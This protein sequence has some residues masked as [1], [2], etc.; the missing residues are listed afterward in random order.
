MFLPNQKNFFFFF[1]QQED[2]IL[3]INFASNNV[4]LLCG[5]EGTLHAEAVSTVG[6]TYGIST[7][8]AT[9]ALQAFSDKTLYPHFSR[10]IG[11]IN[12]Q[13]LALID[14]L[15]YYRNIQGAQGWTDFAV[16][17]SIEFNIGTPE[18]F[19]TL[20]EEND[21]VAVAYQQILEEQEDLS[22]EL[23]AIKSS[24]AR[25]I[26]VFILPQYFGKI[27]L[28]ANELGLVG[29]HYV[30]AST[31][32]LLGDPQIFNGLGEEVTQLSR[33][34]VGTFDYIPLPSDNY[35]PYNN[36]V[37]QWLSLDPVEYPGAGPG[38]APVPFLLFLYDSIMLAGRAMDK[39]D[40]EGLLIDAKEGRISPEV[41]DYA[42]RNVPFNGTSGP[43]VLDEKGDRIQSFA[44][45]YYDPDTL[46]W[47]FSSKWTPE[48]GIEVVNEIIWYSNT[49]EI[50]DLDIRPPFDYWSCH[51]KEKKHDKTGKTVKIQT[52]DGS[53]IDDIDYDYYCDKFIDCKNFS[54]E[55]SDGCENNYLAL[56]IVFGVVTGLLIIITIFILCFILIF[57][58][59]LK[60]QRLKA[61]SPTF[62][63]LLL[64]SIII[65]YSS[66]FTWFGKPHPV[67]CGFQPWL[68][69]LP[70]I[71]MIIS[72]NCKVFRIW[73]IFSAS[74]KRRVITDFHLFVLWIVLMVPAVLIV[75]I[76]TIVS[77]PTAEMKDVGGED[78][79]VCTTGGFTGFPGGYVFFAIFTAYTAV[80][81]LIGAFLSIV[82]RKAPSAFNESKLLA[83][84]IYN[85]ILLGVVIIPVFLVVQPFN[86]FIAWILR[87]I[88]I[89]Y[90]FT[91][92]LVLQFAPSLFLIIFV[93]KL[94]K[95][96]CKIETYPTTDSSP[97]GSNL[98]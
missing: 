91:A 9:S 54:D 66:V 94:A 90:A 14:T 84:S 2:I 13:L 15:D 42:I 3:A 74:F 51:D 69:G 18:S 61:C 44:V 75:T 64:I 4:S 5:L 65:G 26:V 71:S 77:T 29:D 6:I 1:Q 12:G 25:I 59:I 68:L 48:G 85:L 17:T 53:D 78:H 10:T 87:T 32:T 70:T 40:K 37:N 11:S 16:I 30:W 24:K 52:P 82:T 7:L 95:V 56:F 45:Y 50:P 46:Q 8:V 92:T 28:Q 98:N 93:D 63:V 41:W 81:L 33:G 34:M 36:F 38:N 27:I 57:G 67:A 97:I 72:L 73:R 96:D 39:L 79:Y 49:T 22:I 60:Y 76:W 21:F 83:I 31:D 23:N 80:I 62:L 43:L 86:P 88:A 47:D 58:V 20:A 55:S 35:E 89:L 19:I